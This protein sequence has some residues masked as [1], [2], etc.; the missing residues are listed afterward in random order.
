VLTGAAADAP[1]DANKTKLGDRL[2]VVRA[3]EKL[4]DPETLPPRR[5]NRT[6]SSLRSMLLSRLHRA[7]RGVPAVLR[8][9]LPALLIGRRGQGYQRPGERCLRG[10]ER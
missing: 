8:R 4:P 2:A 9:G 5:L 1:D 6:Q 7:H 10:S 3:N